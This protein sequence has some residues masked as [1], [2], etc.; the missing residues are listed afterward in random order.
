MDRVHLTTIIV[1]RRAL[2]RP[3]NKIQGSSNYL[4]LQGKMRQY[5]YEKKGLKKN[6]PLV[7]VSIHLFNLFITEGNPINTLRG[8]DHAYS[9]IRTITI[10]SEDYGWGGSGYRHQT[11]MEQRNAGLKIYRWKEK[12]SSESC[13][14]TEC[15]NTIVF[16]YLPP[17]RMLI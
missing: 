11:L 17:L 16:Y 7:G 10:E 9:S 6:S 3:I 13:L 8:P 2:Y 15:L 5:R 12:K 4:Y 1:A 14:V